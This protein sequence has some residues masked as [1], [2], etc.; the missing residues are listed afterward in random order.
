MYVVK[1]N[2]TR[3]GV[4][5]N[6]VTTRLR[7]L[8]TPNIDPIIVAQKVC[9]GINDGITTSELDNLAA[10]ISI[11]LTTTHPDYAI[12]AANITVSN[13]HKQTK[14]NFFDTFTYLFENGLIAKDVYDVYLF[15]YERI[16]KHISYEKDY[17]F[18][19]FA[20]KTLIK[21]Y[22]FRVDGE[23]VERPQDLIMRV[24]IGIHKDDIE[25]ILETYDLLSN[26]E[27]THATPTLFN[28]GTQRPQLSSCFLLGMKD[29]S[30]EGIYD[31]LKQCALISKWAGGIGLNIHNVRSTGSKIRGTN[32][33]STG[34]IPMLRVYNTT[35][36]YVNQG[37]KRNG[38]FAIYLQIDHPDF[39]EFLEIRKNTGDEETKS[40]DLFQAAW[41]PD[42]FMK[43]VESDG[44]WSFFCPDKA[45]GLADVYG[46]EYE[47][48]YTEYESEGRATRTMKARDLWF[49]IIDTQIETGQPY[50]MYKDA[51][52]KKSNQ[53]NIGI[54]RNSN[55]CCEVTLYTSP[56]EVAVC[57][58]ASISLPKCV[59]NGLFD[60][61]KLEHISY[62]LTKNLNKVIDH[63]FYP[64]PEAR[65]SNMKHRPIGI[66]VQGLADVFMLMRL[67]FESEEAKK[68]NENIFETIYYGALRS[69]NDLAK[70]QGAYETFVGSPASHGILQFDMWGHVQDN[71]R[72]DWRQLKESIKKYGLRNSMLLSPMPTASTSQILGNNECFEPYTS[73]IYLRRTLA[74]EFTVVNKHLVEDLIK[75]GKWS[76]NIKDAIIADNGSVQRLDIPK[77]LK[78][79]YKTVWE[80]KQKTIIDMAADRGKY[81]CQT[82]SMN[83]FL[84]IPDFKKLNSMHF[85][86]WKKG[87]KTGMYYLRSK[88]AA[89]AIKFTIN[90]DTCTTCSA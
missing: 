35:A 10:D 46:D 56:E 33:D 71:S 84:D 5:F 1:R 68:I 60:Y 3:E 29:D 32:G 17:M 41:I 58:L 65:N 2:G 43:R 40:R 28:A 24:S 53:K 34:I 64:V 13:L 74:G 88:P 89:D 14:N 86:G 47:E 19:F 54:I 83:L 27:A 75:I 62:V 61:K 37:G 6:K 11:G 45:P 26:K 9:S 7:K 59:K 18:D 21:G 16:N 80:I 63:N 52:N 12:L 72:Y 20:L 36:R 85:Y 42:L 76:K 79:I 44:D 82:Q 51:I 23:I 69:S 22:L 4:D 15:H 81:I 55:L 39:P 8:S 87:L 77:E 73:N 50:M 31:T 30:I 78:D 57:N 25:S 48:L 70:T 38:S 66:G 49:S 90:P 67:P